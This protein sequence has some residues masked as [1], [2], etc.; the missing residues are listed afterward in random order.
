MGEFWKDKD[1]AV[2]LRKFIE[3]REGKNGLG[4]RLVDALRR[5]DYIQQRAEIMLEDFLDT[6][7]PKESRGWKQI[8][9]RG[10]ADLWLANFDGVVIQTFRG[11]D[12]QQLGKKTWWVSHELRDERT[13]MPFLFTAEQQ[14]NGKPL[15]SPQFKDANDENIQ[16]LLREKLF[17]ANPDPRVLEML[18]VPEAKSVE[19]QL[20]RNHKRNFDP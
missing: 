6:S 1:I 5:F 17:S 12:H 8:P 4:K 18:G 3:T 10:D 13:K 11:D 9:L 20:Y 15:L 19:I 2:P 16:D 14:Q 7:T